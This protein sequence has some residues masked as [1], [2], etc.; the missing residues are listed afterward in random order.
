MAD[1]G[2]GFEGSD[3]GGGR[4]FEGLKVM[5]EVCETSA[6]SAE[7]SS[8]KFKTFFVFVFLFGDKG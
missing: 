4:R 2:A 3:G 6:P 5:D 8:G 1:I 7:S